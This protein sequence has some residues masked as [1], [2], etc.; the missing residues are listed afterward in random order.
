M[1]RISVPSTFLVVFALFANVTPVPADEARWSADSLPPTLATIIDGYREMCSDIG[2]TLEPGFDRPL[3][4]T[5][6]LDRDGVQDFVF[7]PQNMRCSA[8]ATTFCGNGGCQITLAL[9]S[10]EYAD[11]IQI[12]GGAPSL[13][14]NEEGTLLDVWVDNTSCATSETES[15]CR[16]RYSWEDGKLLTSLQARA[17]QD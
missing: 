14:Q 1:R 2:G 17:F 3:I 8:A 6:D 12:M 4:M 16:A 9:S 7:N 5:A 10:Q 13:S 15:S 11:P